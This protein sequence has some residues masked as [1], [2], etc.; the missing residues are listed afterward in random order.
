MTSAANGT[1]GG[2]GN[3]PSRKGW[4]KRLTE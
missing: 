4:W 1:E 2:G 3:K